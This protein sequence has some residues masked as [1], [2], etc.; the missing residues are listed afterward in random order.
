MILGVSI[1]DIISLNFEHFMSHGSAYRILVMLSHVSGS[2]RPFYQS[3]DDDELASRDILCCHDIIYRMAQHVCLRRNGA[4]HY[5]Y[6]AVLS[7][8]GDSR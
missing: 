1:R 8:V 3:Q 7:R 6:G 4:S 5:S 2:H